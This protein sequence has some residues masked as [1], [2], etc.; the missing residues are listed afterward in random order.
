MYYCSPFQLQQ[1]LVDNIHSHID[2]NELNEVITNIYCLMII[3]YCFIP[4]TGCTKTKTLFLLLQGLYSLEQLFNKTVT[5]KNYLKK[6]K[7]LA[8]LSVEKRSVCPFE[9]LL[10]VYD[11]QRSSGA[12]CQWVL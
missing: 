3:I 5:H 4:K 11:S 7:T 9:K 12:I 10:Q 2:Y 8:D 6:V 1:S